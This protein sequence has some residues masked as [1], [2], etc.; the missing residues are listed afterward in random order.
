MA[1]IFVSGV[2][3]F[4]VVVGGSKIHERLAHF[5]IDIYRLVS[6]DG[7]EYSTDVVGGHGKETF[8]NLPAGC[9]RLFVRNSDYSGV[10]AYE[11][12][13]VFPDVSFDAMGVMNYRIK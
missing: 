10:P 2:A 5:F 12:P 4:F 11:N 13:S 3:H 1:Q 9:Y 8:K 6:D 7:K